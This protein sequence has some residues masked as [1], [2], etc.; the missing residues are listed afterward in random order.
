[1]GDWIEYGK[2]FEDFC[3]TDKLSK[4][5][6]LVEMGD[7]IELIGNVNELGGYCD[8]CSSRSAIVKRYKVLVIEELSGKGAE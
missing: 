3:W 1:M 2:L 5:G 4:P 7:G 8:C 6:T